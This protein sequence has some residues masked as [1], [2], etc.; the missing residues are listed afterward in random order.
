MKK[1]MNPQTKRAVVVL[2]I[3]ALLILIVGI[4][5]CSMQL[6]QSDDSPAVTDESDYPSAVPDDETVTIPKDRESS[7]QSN[8]PSESDEKPEDGKS[9]ETQDGQDSNNI[10]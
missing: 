10:S 4:G 9:T 7:N 6:R 3:I 2:S 8:I 5:S 1:K